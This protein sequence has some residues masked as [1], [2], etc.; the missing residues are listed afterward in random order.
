M[1]AKYNLSS[2]LADLKVCYKNCHNNNQ[3]EWHS[4]LHYFLPV[5]SC[6]KYACQKLLGDTDLKLGDIDLR[7]PLRVWMNLR[8]LDEVKKIIDTKVGVQIDQLGQLILL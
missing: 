7:Q 3:I 1:N 5:Y 4:H 2:F 8:D 6:D